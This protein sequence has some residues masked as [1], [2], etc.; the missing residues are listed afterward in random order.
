MAWF[1]TCIMGIMS[2]TVLGFNKGM[3]E[4]IRERALRK[5]ER[6]KGKKA[7]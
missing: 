4:A 1:L 5:A 7:E 2:K 6:E 3:H